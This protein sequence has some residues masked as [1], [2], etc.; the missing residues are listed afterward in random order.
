MGDISVNPG[1]GDVQSGTWEQAYENIKQFIK[2]CEI[3]MHI[4]KSDFLED[5]CGYSFT[6]KADNC[7]WIAEIFM[8]GLPLCQVRF[9]EEPDQNPY[10]FPRLHINGSSWL[11]KYA[12]IGKAEVLKGLSDKLDAL[13]CRCEYIR[14]QIEN[15]K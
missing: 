10:D 8:P 6:L 14:K 5:E 3:P 4:E 15:L 13:E 7:D 2:D 11:W 9:M 12:L 1:P